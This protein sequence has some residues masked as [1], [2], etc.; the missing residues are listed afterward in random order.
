M[1]YVS[2]ALEIICAISLLFMFSA[3]CVFMYWL[4]KP[5]EVV[6][7][8]DDTLPV[9]TKEVPQG[10]ELKLLSRHCKLLPLQARASFQVTGGILPIGDRT[11]IPF[12]SN[13]PV[14]CHD[15]VVTYRISDTVPVG[16]HGLIMNLEYQVNPI[17]F[18]RYR[19]ET[20]TYFVT[21]KL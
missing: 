7:F 14:G 13:G 21:P 12:L 8:K 9:I 11:V 19:K 6:E 5:Y 1:K 17:R 15:T 3:L 18:I 16:E 4:F 2:K 20:Q 10:G